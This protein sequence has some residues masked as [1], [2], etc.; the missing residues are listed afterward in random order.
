MIVDEIEN[1]YLYAGLSDKIERAFKILRDKDLAKKANGRYDVD[2]DLYY[3]VQRYVTKP[4]E[5]TRFEAHKE[6]IDIQ[7]LLKGQEA[8]GYA[9]TRK[10]TANTPYDREKDVTRYES[11]ENFTE[12]KLCKGMFCI[13]YPGDAHKACCQFNGPSDVHKVVIKA[14]T[15]SNEKNPHAA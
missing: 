10:L 12:I 1:A 15:S 11:P 7:F 2:D 3:L 9:P 13:F 4:I 5:R 8:I 14:K 6:H